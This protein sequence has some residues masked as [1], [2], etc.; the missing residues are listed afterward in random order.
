MV[1]HR[2]WLGLFGLLA[3]PARAPAAGN[4]PPE[5][6]V[7]SVV[8]FVL[9]L[10]AIAVLP[11]AAAHWW[12]RNRN[13]ALVAA[14]CA[15]PVV[16]YLFYVQAA[17]GWDATGPLVHELKNYAA[18]MTLLGALYVVSGGVRITGSLSPRPTTNATLLALGALLANLIGTTGASILLIRFVLRINQ[19][20]RHTAHLPIFFIFLV[21]NLGGLLTPLGDPPLFLGFLHG[22]PFAWTLTL[23]REWL[24]VNGVV[25]AVFWV[26]DLLAYRREGEPEPRPEVRDAERL[27]VRGSVNLAL[28][29]GIMGGVLLQGYAPAA[30]GE[31]GEAAGAGVMALAALLSLVLTPRG[32]RSANGFTWGPI[33]E[34]A[35]LFAGIFV[36][37]VP[38]LELV[39]TR[40]RRLAAAEPWHYFWVTGLLSAVLDNAPTY[41]TFATTA[42]RSTDFTALV[43]GR[44]PGLDGPLV[45]RAISCGAVFMGALTYIGNGPNFLIKAI[46]DEAGLRTPSFFGFLLY[47]AAILL[48]VFVLVTFVFFPP[49]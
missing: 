44:V 21:G 11:L 10:L 41:L 42:A 34:V 26:W 24:V 12:H 4:A 36:T 45:L 35:V 48:P 19:G 32:V 9:L 5:L 1:R 23:W 37:M 22:V 46:A 49:G 43:E 3:A 40:G 2:T 13:R 20:R 47:S 18:F 28:L 31:W 25:L 16:G 27:G 6:P 29:A 15:L 14:A 17:T 7:W 39:S 38:A 8:P 33:L 30:W